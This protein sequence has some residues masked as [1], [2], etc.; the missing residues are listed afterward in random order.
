MDRYERMEKLFEL[1]IP[2]RMHQ[3]ILDYLD[4][5]FM[6][7]H[8]LTAV[9]CND[10]AKACAKADDENQRKLPDYVKFF[11]NYAPSNCWGSK[12]TMLNWME[13]KQHKEVADGLVRD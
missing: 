5:G 7:G 11:W 10:L 2:E 8:F 13:I 12:E 4:H 1:G 6:P 9:I 3:G